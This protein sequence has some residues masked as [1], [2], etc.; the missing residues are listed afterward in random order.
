MAKSEY[1]DDDHNMALTQT[2]FCSR[3]TSLLY[4]PVLIS[5]VQSG[6]NV[7]P[8]HYSAFEYPQTLCVFQNYDAS[9]FLADLYFTC[10][11][12]LNRRDEP[13]ATK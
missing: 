4:M 6:D 11:L 10:T 7:P 9:V 1:V 12:L 8:D 3:W 13:C 5:K 2:R